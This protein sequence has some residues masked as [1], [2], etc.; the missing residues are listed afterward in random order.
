MSSS[1]SK[2]EGSTT[3]KPGFLDESPYDVEMGSSEQPQEQL[4]RDLGAR[5]INM[6]A[7]AGMIV[8]SYVYLILSIIS[9]KVP[10]HVGHSDSSP[11][12]C[13]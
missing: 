11:K 1:S 13:Q 4:K 2:L 3:M 12:S 10:I 9:Y 7:I 8:R 6:I 5:H